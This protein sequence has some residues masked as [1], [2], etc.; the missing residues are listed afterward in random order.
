MMVNERQSITDA[1]HMFLKSQKLKESS[2]I[3]Y[4]YILLKF[5]KWLFEVASVEINEVCD[6]YAE[7]LQREGLK[8]I[9]IRTYMTVIRRFLRF[10]TKIYEH[11]N[12]T[13]SENSTIPP[14]HPSI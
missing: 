13:E 2:L 5:I 11:K 7:Y 14:P 12:H 4:E 8:P 6:S 10:L 1:I 3:T 9:T